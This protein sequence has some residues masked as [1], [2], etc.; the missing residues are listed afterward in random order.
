VAQLQQRSS[1][2][3]EGKHLII[4]HIPALVSSDDSAQP[5]RLNCAQ[6][7]HFAVRQPEQ[8]VLAVALRSQLVAVAGGTC[9]VLEGVSAAVRRGA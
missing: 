9:L 7:V 3:Q 1:E 5:R 6:G 8:P 4:A 2:L